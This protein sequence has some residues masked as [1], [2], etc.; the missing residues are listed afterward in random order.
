VI[1]E[2]LERGD[3]AVLTIA[4]LTTDAFA[5][6]LVLFGAEQGSAELG[7]WVH[8]GRRGKGLARDAVALAIKFAKRSGFVRLTARTLPENQASQRVLEQAGFISGDVM[9]DVAPSGQEVALIPYLCDLG[10]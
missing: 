5:G 1:R 4:D 10:P 9:R 6:S 8:P 3:L 2:G 7:F